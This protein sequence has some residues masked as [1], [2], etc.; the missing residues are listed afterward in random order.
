MLVALPCMAA[1]KHQSLLFWL[2]RTEPS[3]LALALTLPC[4]VALVVIPLPLVS[5]LFER[6]AFGADDTAA[7][8]AKAT[9]QTTPKPAWSE[10]VV[11]AGC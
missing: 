6:G 10:V 1:W 3:E 8:Q 5:V 7:R 9:A 4:A 2:S 11:S